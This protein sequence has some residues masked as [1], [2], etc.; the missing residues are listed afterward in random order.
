MNSQAIIENKPYITKRELGVILE[1]NGKNLDRKIQLLLDK[2]KIVQLKKGVYVSRIY[3]LKENK[4]HQEFIANFLCYPSY[5]STEYVLQK[6]NVIPEAVYAYT[7]ITTKTTRSYQNE[8]GN[9]IYQTIKKELFTGFE[10]KRFIENYTI[11]EATKAKGLF[12]WLYLKNFENSLEEE[13]EIDLRI[14]WDVFD[15]SDLKEFE[16]Y[17][18]KSKMKKMREIFSII[19][20]LI[21]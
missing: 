4:F 7:S 17:T 15:Q 20:N 5:L 8:L 2:G 10:E 19:N 12:D 18:N 6:N 13:L 16:E 14:N 21:Q 9:F 11:K 1:K 3:L